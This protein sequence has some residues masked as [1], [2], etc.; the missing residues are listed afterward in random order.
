MS[1]SCFCDLSLG[2]NFTVPSFPRLMSKHY[3]N[4]QIGFVGIHQA[5]ILMKTGPQEAVSA[6]GNGWYFKGDSFTV[7]V[8]LCEELKQPFS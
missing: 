3:V 1:K 7:K 4:P 8:E 2:D 5:L 6:D